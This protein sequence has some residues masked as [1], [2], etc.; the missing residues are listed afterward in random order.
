MKKLLLLALVTILSCVPVTRAE[1]STEKRQEIEKMLRL[2]GMERMVGQM[3]TQM[4]S[5]LKTQVPQVPEVFWVKFQ[6]KMDTR[7]LIEKIIPIYDKY[8]TIEDLK[9]INAFYE[10]PAGQK[11]LSTLPQVMQE[12]MKIGQE[13]GQRIGKQAAEEAEQELKKK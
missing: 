13:W 11:V 1:M 5:N 4:L 10:G 7:E 9:A 12:S 2:T 6:Q 8:Y 3:E